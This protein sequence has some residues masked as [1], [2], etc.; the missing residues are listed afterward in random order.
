MVSR[1]LH[2]V[3]GGFEDKQHVM[4]THLELTCGSGRLPRKGLDPK[5]FIDS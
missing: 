3:Q 5:R 1:V 4:K 2:Q